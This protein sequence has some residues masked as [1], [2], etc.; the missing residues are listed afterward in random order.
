MKRLEAAEKSQG[1]PGNIWINE[2]ATAVGEL[3]SREIWVEKMFSFPLGWMNIF[4]L[5][6]SKT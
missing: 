1:K 6:C 4:P 3:T 2:I 5:C